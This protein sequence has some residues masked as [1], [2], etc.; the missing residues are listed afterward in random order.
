MKRT[1]TALTYCL[2]LVAHHNHH[3]WIEREEY[4]APRT[5]SANVAR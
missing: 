4:D 5:V 1:L 3:A 2:M